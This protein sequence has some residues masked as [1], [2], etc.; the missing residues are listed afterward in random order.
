MMDEITARKKIAEIE[1][2]TK[3]W[4]FGIDPAIEK[5]LMCLFTLI[6][7]TSQGKKELGQAHVLLLDLPGVGKTDLMRSL[8]FAIGAKS[9]RIDGSPEL[10]KSQV[11]GCEIYNGTLGMF[12]LDKGP[13]F[14]HIILFDEINRTHP[15]AQSSFLEAMEERI[16]LLRVTDNER[17]ISTMKDFPLF[18]ISD[19]PN[20]K[21]L[22]F[23]VVATGNPIEQ[24]GTYPVPEA[25]LDRFTAAFSIGFPPR[26]YEKQIRARNVLEDKSGKP[27][28]IQQVLSLEE[29]L[30]IS[31]LILDCVNVPGKEC[32]GA[33]RVDEYSMR[34]IENSRPGFMARKYA[35]D[36]LREYVDETLVLGASPRTNLHFEALARTKAFFAGRYHITTDDIK[37]VAPLVMGHRIKIAPGLSMKIKPAEAIQMIIDHTEVP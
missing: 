27:K 11:F 12:F 15:K 29:A 35:S 5:M 10:E 9:A 16:A 2:Q 7:Y 21:R 19:D 28:E 30:Q 4:L 23:W 6:P 8:S 31:R 14:S 37:Y 34:L 26:E 3:K 18:P 22:F 1:K 20:E 36:E 25:Q 13:I 24:E 17:M 32:D 33:G